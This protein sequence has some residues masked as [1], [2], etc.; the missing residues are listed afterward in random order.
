MM[1]DEAAR[2]AR[3]T[4]AGRSSYLIAGG[5]VLAAAGWM[6]SGL[7][8]VQPTAGTAPAA[9]LVEPKMTSVRVREVEA[10][11]VDREIVVNGR[12]APARRVELRAES[13]GR[14]I[15]LGSA[16]G[17]LA[18]AGDLVVEI[19]PRAH[20]ALV[21]EATAMLRMRE[22]EYDAATKLGAKGFQA[23]TKVAES[24]AELEA[25]QAALEQAEIELSHSMILA[26]FAGVVERAVELG[27]FVDVG[28]RVASVIELD[29]LLVTGEV[30]ETRL[31]GLA[32]GMPGLA[33]LNTCQVVHG[34]VRYIGREA[35]PETR[36]FAIELEVE[37]PGSLVA[38]G[39]SAEL[40][41][42]WQQ[43]EAHRV[44]AGLLSLDDNGEVG[45]KALAD[46]DTVVFYPARIVRAEADAVWL[47]DLP[48]QLRL[49]TVGQGFVR[50]GDHVRT[51]SEETPAAPVAAREPQA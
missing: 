2:P 41:I 19:D 43:V 11:E 45:I 34:R 17:T 51:L 26:P 1:D 29:P 31:G 15:S 9:R 12:T 36:T 3:R 40:R 10:A 46:D 21:E 37:N 30:A 16:R 7:W 4:H 8:S 20:A 35:D 39:V 23:T 48:R 24:K 49:I 44:S 22:I 38:G 32:V 27:D 18:A 50:P 13:G 6:L 5:L 28:D 14:V 42:V 25:A 33:R 47:I